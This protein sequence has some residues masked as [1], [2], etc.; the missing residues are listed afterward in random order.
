MCQTGE[1]GWDECSSLLLH[2]VPR[3]S[4]S[5]LAVR[6]L[7]GALSQTTSCLIHRFCF[8]VPRLSP[9]NRAGKRLAALVAADL[10]CRCCCCCC[11]CCC[12]C[13]FCCCLCCCCCCCCCCCGVDQLLKS[14]ICLGM[15][16]TRLA[17]SS[18]CCRSCCLSPSS[19]SDYL[20]D[21][22]GYR[23]ISPHLTILPASS[24]SKTP[25]QT[26]PPYGKLHF[27]C[28]PSVEQKTQTDRY[29]P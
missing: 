9:W 28:H 6:S 25:P 12:C 18:R 26:P 29:T 23:L 24:N 13:F 21:A 8:S 3:E 22:F 5:L 16:L 27:L 2:C 11:Y 14:I 17:T 4:P 15:L 7:A 10:P 1:G 20:V 19:S